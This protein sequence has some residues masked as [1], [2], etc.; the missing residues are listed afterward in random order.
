MTLLGGL[1][2]DPMGAPAGTWEWT[3]S[4]EL[5]KGP[6]WSLSGLGS[7][8]TF[9]GGPSLATLVG[10]IPPLPAFS[11]FSTLSF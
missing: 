5:G 3:R 11:F 9:S 10:C 6:A 8:V 1:P 7:N 2:G 4:R